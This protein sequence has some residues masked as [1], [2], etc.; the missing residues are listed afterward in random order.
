MTIPTAEPTA[1][2]VNFRPPVGAPIWK[3][4]LW[5]VVAVATPEFGEI[6]HGTAR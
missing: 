5:A 6:A 4:L 2:K 3:H 1:L